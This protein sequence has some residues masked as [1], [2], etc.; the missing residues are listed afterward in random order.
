MLKRLRQHTHRSVRYPGTDAGIGEPVE[1]VTVQPPYRRCLAFNHIGKAVHRH[2]RTSD[3]RHDRG[4]L[5]FPFTQHATRPSDCDEDA[6]M[7]LGTQTAH[8]TRIRIG[9]EA[10]RIL[11]GV[12]VHNRKQRLVRYGRIHGR[13]RTHHASGPAPRQS[14]DTP[15]IC[16]PA[17]ALHSTPR[18]HPRISA[19][20]LAQTHGVPCFSSACTMLHTSRMPGITSTADFPAPHGGERHPGQCPFPM[21]RPPEGHR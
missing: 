15:G 8:T 10:I 18:C 6:S 19:W 7:E 21:H 11:V 13:P 2:T 14:P 1:F 5:A 3:L 20:H 9:H 12:V 16:R 17:R 4:G